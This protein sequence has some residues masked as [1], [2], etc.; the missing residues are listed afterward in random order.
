MKVQTQ[1]F[2][3]VAG[4]VFL[5]A[6]GN[7]PNS[8]GNVA[9]M[10]FKQIPV[11]YPAT[12]KDT[13]VKDTYFGVNVSDPYRWLED[14]QS[15][16][17]KDWVKKQ[18]IVT[19]GYLTQIPTRSRILK[20][21]EAIWNFEKF[22]VPFKEG[23]RYFFFKNNGLQNQSVLYAQE[24]LESQPLVI[25]DPNTFS[26]DGTASLQEYGFSKDGRYLAY[27]ISK[28]G[29]DWRN[30]RIRD[31]QTGT[32]L[33]DDIQWAKFTSIAW[34][35][36]GFY[37]SRYPEPKKGDELKGA[38]ENSAIYYHALGTA[39]AQDELIHKDPAHPNYYFGVSVS[40]DERFVFLISS[41]STSG[42]TLAVKDLSKPNPSFVPVSNNFK[43]D[44]N[45][46]DNIGDDLL[47]LTN[48]NAPNQR[49]VR[50]NANRTDEQ[51]W[52]T[53]IAED[54]KDVLQNAQIVGDKLIAQYLHDAHSQLKVFSLEGQLV[55]TVDL[56]EI[57]TVGA[58][59]GKK[60][61]NTAFYSFQSFLR[62]N[63]IYALNLSDLSSKVFKAPK[64][65]FDPDAYTTEQVWYSSKDGTKVPM[66]ITRKKN[67][68]FD[69]SNPTLL[70]G[71]GGFNISLTPSF[72]ASRVA[73]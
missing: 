49:I 53:F 23:N 5:T 32:D 47:V 68:A 21:L 57:G 69:G 61:D 12:R 52:E 19:Q 41:E 54:S 48:H 24:T 39:Q 11:T 55:G 34:Q 45:P 26:T 70:Y 56:P 15:A 13:T 65:D 72:S 18:N 22:S 35:G 20:R 51:F 59:S 8:S 63:T 30:I 42:N 50:I 1:F 40:D 66:F 36:N 16:E 58:V 17:T 43:H 33:A 44:F 71:Y 60:G 62:P 10:E 3:A 2:F 67:I 4:I 7:G 28:G 9:T 25:L 27:A 37:Y 46:I 31:L 29:S 6:C 14:D 64:V 73:L 38:N